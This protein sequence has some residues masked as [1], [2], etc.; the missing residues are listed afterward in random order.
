VLLLCP[1]FAVVFTVAL[2]LAVAAALL[3]AVAV[4][5]ASPYL[6]A[7]RVRAHRALHAKP[8]ASPRPLRRQRVSPVRVGAPQVKSVA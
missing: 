5:L 7:R 2:V 8:Q 3:A 4:L 6:L 1:P